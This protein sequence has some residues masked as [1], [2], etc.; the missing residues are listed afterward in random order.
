MNNLLFVTIDPL[1]LYTTPSGTHP[2]N[3]LIALQKEILWLIGPMPALKRTIAST[4]IHVPLQHIFPHTCPSSPLWLFC[5]LPTLR[6][7]LYLPINITTYPWHVE[8]NRSPRGNLYSPRENTQTSHRRHTRPGLTPCL[9]VAVKLQCQLLQHS[10]I[11][12][13]RWSKPHQSILP[14]HSSKW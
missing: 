5:H 4:Y 12:V 7:N 9:S 2:T 8:K 6:G 11:L 10:A 1:V 3:S 14:F 13:S